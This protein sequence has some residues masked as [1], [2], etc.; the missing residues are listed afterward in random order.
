MTTIG[1]DPPLSNSSLYEH[2]CLGNI[3]HSYKSA[4]KCNDQQQYKAIIKSEM[5]SNP[6]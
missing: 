1:F 6:E 4:S 3:N 5:G 2:R